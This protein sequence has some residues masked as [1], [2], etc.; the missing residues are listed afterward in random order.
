MNDPNSGAKAVLGVVV[1]A[2]SFAASMVAEPQVTGSTALRGSQMLLGATQEVID[3][4]PGS[5]MLASG[6]AM[7]PIVAQS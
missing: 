3:A 5:D 4:T 2:T 6:M 1:A 7:A